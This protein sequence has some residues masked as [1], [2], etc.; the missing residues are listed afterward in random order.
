MKMRTRFLF[1]H[2]SSFTHTTD[3]DDVGR[4]LFCIT[5][6]RMLRISPYFWEIC[7]RRV[8]WFSTGKSVPSLAEVLNSIL[9]MARA[10]HTLVPTRKNSVKL[11]VVSN[12]K[13]HVKNGDSFRFLLASMSRQCTHKTILKG[14]QGFTACCVD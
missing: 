10:S 2:S 1:T 9:H 5:C 11:D 7:T 12:L 3:C 8:Y 6:M 13:L 4:Y 14:F